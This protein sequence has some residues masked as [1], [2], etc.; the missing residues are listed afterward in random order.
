MCPSGE[1]IMLGATRS[2]TFDSSFP[3]CSQMTLLPLYGLQLAAIC[4]AARLTIPGHCPAY[5]FIQGAQIGL[6]GGQAGAPL[7]KA[8][9]AWC[10]THMSCNSLIAINQAACMA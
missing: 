3:P 6:P 5:H 1:M 2:W 4:K 8:E 9:H 10:T 7:Q